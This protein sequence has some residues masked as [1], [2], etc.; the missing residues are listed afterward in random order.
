MTARLPALR[1]SYG[2]FGIVTE[3]TFRVYRKYYI[4]MEHRKVEPEN[5]RTFTPR[6]LVAMGLRL[7]VQSLRRSK[8][9]TGL[10][11]LGILIGMMKSKYTEKKHKVD[12]LGG[13]LLVASWFVQS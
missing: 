8:L 5:G 2:L 13:L 3:V 11:T 12:Y 7:A 10:T 6:A 9:R 1:C 4:S